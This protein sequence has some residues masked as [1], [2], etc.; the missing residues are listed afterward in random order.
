MRTYVSLVVVSMLCL[1]SSVAVAHPG[2]GVHDASGLT[3]SL[4]D[5]SMLWLGLGL[6]VATGS[7]GALLLRRRAR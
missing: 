4:F 3:H 7:V 6:V 5:H 1:V 2:H